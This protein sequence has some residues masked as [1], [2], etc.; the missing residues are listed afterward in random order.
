MERGEKN[1]GGGKY[2][3]VKFRILAVIL[4]VIILSIG[5]LI[6]MAYNM[7]SR[8]IE[9]NSYDMLDSSAKNQAIQIENWLDNNLK[10]FSTVKQSI[11]STDYSEGAIKNILNQYYNFNS[12]FS[13][14]LYVS[15][16]QGNMIAAEKSKIK[17]DNA[18]NSNWFVDGL[19]HMNMRYGT[20]YK[21]SDGI[22]VVSATGLIV[23]NGEPAGVIGADLTLDRINVIINSLIEMDGAQAF[24]LDKDTGTVLAS[25]DSLKVHSTL[26]TESSSPFYSKISEKINENNYNPEILNNNIVTIK[27]IGNTNWILVSYA[28]VSRIFEKLYSLRNC[29]VIL[30]AAAIIILML[31]TERSIHIIINPLNKMSRQIIKMADGDFTVDIDVKGNNEISL[32]AESLNKFIVSMRSMLNNIKV[33]SNA[34]RKQ[35]EKS[36]DISSNL[37]ELSKE[38]TESMKYLNSVVEQVNESTLKIADTASNLADIVSITTENGSVVKD[39]MY[40]TVQMSESGKKNIEHVDYAIKTIQESI[41]ELETLIENVGQSSR[42]IN[43]IVSIIGDIAENTN[44][45]ALNA[46]IEA[47]RAGESGKG[48]AVVASEIGGLANNSSS[49]AN[50]IAKLATNITDMIKNVT[51]KVHESVEEVNESAGLIKNSISIFDEIYKT[52]EESDSLVKNM[53]SRVEE[54]NRAADNMVDISQAQ[55]QHTEEITCTS[56]QIYDLSSNITDSS[57]S[58]SEGADELSVTAEKLEKEVEVF[59]L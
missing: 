43:N 25:S 30:A 13:E 12:N 29:M 32:I 42:E 2:I 1:S 54:V 47:A 44:L 52:I 3:S 45:L 57:R 55:S 14:G 21:N 20:P 8:I 11:G 48:F 50:E 34:Q 22:Y 26:N 17:L 16:M 24:L 46:S 49:S 31:L 23:N 35:S 27:D 15:D 10:V 37:F 40:E 39:K 18:L 4:P 38:Q 6:L 59:K 5:A 9:G 33:I 36:N 28:P 56:N 51:N 53:I 7:S 19:T 58:V 41:G